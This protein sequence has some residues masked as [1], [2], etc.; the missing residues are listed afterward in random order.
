[1]SNQRSRP[2]A[3]TSLKFGEASLLDVLDT[4]RVLWETFQSYA[5]ARF[6]LSVAL[7]E[8]ERLVRNEF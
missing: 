2:H 4:Q 3:R 8:L 1:M 7:T 5:E 6:E